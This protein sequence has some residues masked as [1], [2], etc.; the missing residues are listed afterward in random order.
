L[1]DGTTVNVNDLLDHE[2]AR[3]EA[4]YTAA[5]PGF[6]SAF[7]ASQAAREAEEEAL[8]DPDLVYIRWLDLRAAAPPWPPGLSQGAARAYPRSGAA[9]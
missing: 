1:P 2:I 5:V 4:E 3:L 8:H 6:A 9:E 7:R